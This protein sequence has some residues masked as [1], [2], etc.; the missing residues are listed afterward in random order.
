MVSTVTYSIKGTDRVLALLDTT[1]KQTQMKNA[2][3][4]YGDTMKR[5][6]MS[7]TPVDTWFLHDS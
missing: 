1:K 4:Y 6:V 3:K 7:R 2:V 5:E